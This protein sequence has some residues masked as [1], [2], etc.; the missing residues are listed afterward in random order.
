MGNLFGKEKPLKEVLRENKRMISRAVRELDRE[1]A[2][3][4]REEKRLTIEI[5]KA[6]KQQ[7]MTA[8]T[9]MAKDLVRTRAH[10]TKFIEM[11]SHLQSCALKL[12]TVKSHQA[13]ADA[14]KNT[15]TAMMKMNKAVDAPAI[16]KMMKEFEK[17]NMKSELMQEIMG[18]MMDDVMEQ[19][20]DAEEEDKI[21]S[22][23]LD[24]IG[25]TFSE[26]IPDAPIQ[27][28]G[29]QVAEEPVKNTKVAVA[30]ANDSTLNDLEARLNNLN[31]ESPKA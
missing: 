1:R 10:V 11:R 13:M 16:N 20:G 12:Q 9:I 14:M 4:E 29:T 17:E 30:S 25:V 22:Q 6:A 21:V 28:T 24:E 2:S 19:D 27:G 8:V 7:Q 3:L 26:A 31:N 18:D 23:V 5:K 15:T